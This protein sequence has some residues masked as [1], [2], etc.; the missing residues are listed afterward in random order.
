VGL[1]EDLKALQD[2]RDKGEI[3][4]S[5]YAVARDALWINEVRRESLIKHVVA[6]RRRVIGFRLILLLA[7]LI[8]VLA[9]T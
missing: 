7:I 1:P 4:E 5:E 8:G 9:Q 2:R 6:R 3:N